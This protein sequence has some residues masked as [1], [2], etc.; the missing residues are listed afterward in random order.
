MSIWQKLL[1]TKSQ[2][3]GGGRVT[4]LREERRPATGAP[5]LF[6]TFRYYQASSTEAA[7]E[8]L[9]KQEITE[10]L[11]YIGVE[12]PHGRWVKDCTGLYDA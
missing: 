1:G 11:F 9:N 6:A 2:D 8:F 4:F 5:T 12:T 10:K 7:L 3:Y